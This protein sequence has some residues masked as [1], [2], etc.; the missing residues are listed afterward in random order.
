MELL[1]SAISSGGLAGMA[2]QYMC[3]LILAVAARLDLIKLAAP[4]GFMESWWFIA[5]VALFWILTVLPAYSTLLS[6]GVMNVVNAI[7]NLLSGFVV[8]ISGA[9]LTLA[10]VGVIAEMHPELYH[11]LETLRIFSPDGKSVGLVGWM[12]AGGG[13]LTATALTGARFLAKPAVSTATGSVASVSA[14]AYAT[15]ENAGA[16]LLMALAYVL[17]RVNPWLVVGL[18]AVM[19]LTTLAILVWAVYQLWK[20]G[21]GIGRLVRMIET[22]PR[23]GLAVVAEFLVW[24]WG[25]LLWGEWAGGLA[26]FVLWALWLITVLFA[27]PALGAG[28][29]AL[30]AAVPPL[31]FVASLLMMAVEV[32]SVVVGLYIGLRGAGSLMA[33]LQERV[34]AV[35]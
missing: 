23:A 19:A 26:R 13:A 33:Q 3:L 30:L 8:P 24:G 35:A 5:V 29:A 17:V 16:V 6:P 15:L 22:H 7:T 14:P 32:A 20:L 34:V 1:L 4:V 18:L 27:L 28:L 12:V 25:R 31:A 2:N 10:S 9:L 21:K 11:L